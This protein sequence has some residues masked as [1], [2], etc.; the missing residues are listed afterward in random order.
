VA[1]AQQILREGAP[2]VERYLTFLRAGCADYSIDLLKQAGVDMTSPEPVAAALD[3][4]GQLVIEL[5]E[6]AA[7]DL[8]R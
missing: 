7:P 6:L 5:E 1:L 2:A 3:T 8:A 4:F